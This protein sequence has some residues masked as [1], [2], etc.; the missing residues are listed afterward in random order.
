MNTDEAAVLLEGQ[1]AFAA[2]ALELVAGA[3]NELTLL[4]Q[5]LDPRTY[6]TEVFVDAVSAF[7]LQHRNTRV[8]M[9]VTHPQQAISGGSRMVELGRRLSSFIEFREINAERRQ[10]LSEEYLIADGRQMLVRQYP[11]DLHSR[12]YP[13]APHLARLKLKEFDLLWNESTTAQELRDLKL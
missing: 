5:N 4:T 11:T 9:L 1:A 2:R 6:C 10:S 7:V 3:R 12:T 13:E 8:R